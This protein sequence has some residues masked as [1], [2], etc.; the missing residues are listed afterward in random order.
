MTS[1]DN[2]NSK[3][4]EDIGKYEVLTRIDL[5]NRE[6]TDEDMN[7]VV[8]SA[9]INKRCPS[10]WLYDNMLTSQGARILADSIAN[11]NTLQELFLDGNQILDIG[12]HYLSL[13]LNC[14]TL[15][16]LSLS[17]NGITDQ[18]AEYLAES[19]KTN[20]TLRRLWLYHNQIGDHGIQM[21]ADTL[22]RHNTSLEWLDLRS[23]KLV[24]D[25]SFDSLI[26]MLESNHSLKKFWM[27][28]CNLS[29]EYKA[30]LRQAAKSKMNFDLGA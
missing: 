6:L 15:I 26:L 25:A 10:L 1:I 29:Y 13:I 22:T 11:N 14:S 3:L 30:K 24:T 2:H 17:E 27:E 4:Q 19:L 28:Y 7:I 21:F 9:I 5:N 8:E 12:V 16:S 23:N 20:R 18:G